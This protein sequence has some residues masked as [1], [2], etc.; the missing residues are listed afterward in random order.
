MTSERLAELKADSDLGFECHATDAHALI[1][2]VEAGIK[3]HTAAC[4]LKE[5]TMSYDEL[6]A[7]EE[8]M[9]AYAATM[10]GTP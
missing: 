1:K 5:S 2:I 3:L 7:F 9:D 4:I 8:A 6:L 10:K